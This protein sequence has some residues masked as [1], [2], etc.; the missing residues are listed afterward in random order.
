MLYDGMLCVLILWQVFEFVYK[1][2]MFV[3]IFFL[4]VLVSNC[5]YLFKYCYRGMI[6]F[7]YESIGM[8]C[9]FVFFRFIDIVEF[10][11]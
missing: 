10:E 9:G 7:I 4:F 8:F 5:V 1:N 2:C 3:F 11:V 6:G